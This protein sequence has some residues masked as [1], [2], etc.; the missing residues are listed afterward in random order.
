[1]V[2]RMLA[3]LRDALQCSTPHLAAI[4]GTPLATVRKWFSGERNPS[5]AASRLVWLLHTQT[6]TP[7]LLEKNPGLWLEWGGVKSPQDLHL[8]QKTN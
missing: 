7:G 5:G 8:F 1:V 4:L 3:E 6:T 2:R